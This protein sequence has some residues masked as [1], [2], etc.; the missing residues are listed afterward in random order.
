MKKLDVLLSK[1]IVKYVLNFI[2]PILIGELIS[3]II[4]FI[5]DKDFQ[6]EFGI[7]LAILIISM[8][9]YIFC[10][11]RYFDMEKTL[12]EKLK[13]LEKANH[14][15]KAKNIVYQKI[16][17]L[18]TSLFNSTATE[19]NRIAN[20]LS[21]KFQLEKWNYKVA[22]KLICSAV[23]EILCSLTGKD[24]FSVNIVVYDFN[25]KGKSKNIKMIAEKSKFETPSD[26][27]EK[28]MYMSSNKDFYAVKIFNKNLSSPTI[29]TTSE[30]IK[31]KFVFSE[32]KK[33]HPNYTQYVG[34]PIHCDSNKM[35]S[36][37]QI[38][39]LN[40]AYIGNN[41]KDIADIINNF[42]LPFT[43]FALMNNKMEKLAINSISL[44]N[45]PKED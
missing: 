13:T 30:E 35:V 10:I 14:L 5:K 36:L 26:T 17:V 40:D 8:A 3:A 19:I 44:I 9:M 23:Y 38:C 12:E 16:S 42:I 24:D 7:V 33:E 4:E 43:Y 2:F 28:T 1:K 15:L 11:Y 6:R 22:S 39:S 45:K 18:L 20:D 27:F 25:A 31:E 29:L 37:L 21:Q 32:D 34:I 41:K